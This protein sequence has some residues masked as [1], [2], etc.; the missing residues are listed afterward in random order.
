M[1]GSSFLGTAPAMDLHR[2]RGAVTPHLQFSCGARLAE[3]GMLSLEREG[4]GV[5][6]QPL[7]GL[8]GSMRAGE[9]LGTRAW[10]SRKR[11]NGFPLPE[12]RVGWD[13]KLFPVRPW[14]KLPQEVVTAPSLELCQAR[15]DG[16]WSTLG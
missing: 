14:N 6:S 9:A 8:K 7:P 5:T 11:E 13:L 3:L 12:G 15:Q 4:S 16:V 1:A 10:S 2:A